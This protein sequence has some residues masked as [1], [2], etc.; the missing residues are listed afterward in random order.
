MTP[1]NAIHDIQFVRAV[2]KA[3]SRISNHMIEVYLSTSTTFPS[4]VL[5]ECIPEI[6]MDGTLTPDVDLCFEI[7]HIWHRN[8]YQVRDRAIKLS[9]LGPSQYLRGSVPIFFTHMLIDKLL[10]QLVTF[11]FFK[12]NVQKTHQPK[13]DERISLRGRGF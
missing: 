13:V 2:K 9:I 1:I 12:I 7:E 4:S 11:I 5:I 8:S 10:G 6:A 3:F